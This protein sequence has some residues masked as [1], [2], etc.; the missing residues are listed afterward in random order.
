MILLTGCWPPTFIGQK[1]VVLVGK[2]ARPHSGRQFDLQQRQTGFRHAFSPNGNA[3]SARLCWF[4]IRAEGSWTVAFLT[5][6]RRRHHQSSAW[7]ACQRLCTDPPRPRVF[8][9]DAGQTMSS[10]STWSTKP[11]IHHLD[12]CRSA[13]APPNPRCAP[14]LFCNP[15]ADSSCVPIAADNS[16]LPIDGQIVTLC[17]WAHRRRDHGGVIFIDLRDRE[18]PAQVVCDP[19]RPTC[20]RS[21]NPSATSSA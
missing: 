13:T 9:D 20:S 7:R 18:G 11:Q 2:A 1:L 16:T 17:G 10:N 21:P 4:N 14:T 3:P 12:G 5:S 8:P 6:A 19:D 15:V